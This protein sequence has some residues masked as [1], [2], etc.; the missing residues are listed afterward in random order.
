MLRELK[1]LFPYFRKYG[2]YY[3]GGLLFIGLTDVGQLYLPQL[4]RRAIDTISRGD[5]AIRDILNI[6]LEMIAV[7]AVIG[8]GRY[9]W[10]ILIFGTSK[11]IERDLRDDFYGHL[12]LLSPSFY[13][14]YKTGDLMAR[15]TNDMDAIRTA[16]GIGL[17]LLVD[18]LIMTTSILVIMISRNPLMTLLAISPLPFLSVAMIFFGRFMA[19]QFGKVQAGFGEMTDMVQESISGIRVLKTFVKEKIFLERFNI[20]NRQYS[21]RNLSMM[22]T[23]GFYSPAVSFFTGVTTVVLLLLGG[24]SVIEGSLTPG[25]FTAFFSYLRML[26]WPVLGAGTTINFIQRAAASLGRINRVLEERP[27]ITSPFPETAITGR[28]EG[29]ISIRNLNYSYPG[30]ETQVLTDISLEIPP[31]KILGILG[32]TGSGKSTL[33]QLLPRILDPPAGTVFVDGNDVGS[34][35]LGSLRAGISM[36]PQDGFL[37][38]SSIRDNIDFGSGTGEEQLLRQVASI[39]TIERDFTNFPDGWHTVI[40]ERGVTLSG[41]QKQRVAISRALAVPA[42]IHI[43]DDALSSVDLETEDLI[44]SKLLPFLAGKTLILIAHRISTLKM[45]DSIVVL[46][47][48]RIIQKGTHEELA[49]R[50]GFYADIFKIQQLAR[51]VRNGT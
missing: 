35:A 49:A 2:F 12:Q 25:E 44:L 6:A 29:Q 9:F 10:R 8:L 39:S 36:V 28:I 18:S 21:E 7:G 17:A 43:F 41:G 33:V 38:S 11:K 27:D 42:A 5:F 26:I 30:T 50:E 47:E 40:G 37:F 32:K 46:D 51:A 19:D 23:W 20:K 16:T 45:A 22:R 4:I 15:L 48:G 31:G 3:L 1:T 24:R 13:A 34:Y 14:R